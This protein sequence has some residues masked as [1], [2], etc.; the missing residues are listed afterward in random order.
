MHSKGFSRLRGPTH[1]MKRETE[2]FVIRMTKNGM[3]IRNG[4]GERLRFTASEAL[5][6]LD[7]LR[8][9][10]ERLE[11]I[12]RESSPLPMRIHF[13]RAKDRE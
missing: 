9:E 13:G 5:M 3:T 4:Q 2:K 11:T 6:L 8:E 12:A 10:K 1:E 7:I